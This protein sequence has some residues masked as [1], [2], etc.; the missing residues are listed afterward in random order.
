MSHTD[1][2]CLILMS[3]VS[4][5]F[6]LMTCVFLES[7]DHGGLRVVDGDIAENPRAHLRNA[8]PCTSRGCMWAKYRDGKV[9][10]PYAIANH[11]CKLEKYFVAR[12]R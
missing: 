10:V 3:C 2:W 9:Y 6:T 1:D 12:L 8:D 7:A 5:F 4:W 11:Y